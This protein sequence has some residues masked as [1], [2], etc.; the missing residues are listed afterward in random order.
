MKINKYQT[1]SMKI[2]CNQRQSILWENVNTADKRWKS[3]GIQ[4]NVWNQLRSM[5]I[6]GVQWKHMK[7]SENRR[8]NENE[9]LSMSINEKEWKPLSGNQNHRESIKTYEI[10][11]NLCKMKNRN[12]KI[13]WASMQWNGIPW[14][15]LVLRW[16]DTSLGPL[17]PPNPFRRWQEIL[18]M[19]IRTAKSGHLVE[20]HVVVRRRAERNAVTLFR[21]TLFIHRS[22]SK[23]I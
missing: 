13:P 5:K 23:K 4:K 10:H 14:I 19:K 15:L 1:I 2:G 22:D 7:T 3:C 20:L 11:E 21:R 16:W 6:F 18:F 12:N 17:R 9:L 8:S